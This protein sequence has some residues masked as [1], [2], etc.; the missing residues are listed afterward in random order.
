MRKK[1]TQLIVLD[2]NIVLRSETERA[3]RTAL[4]A[5]LGLS[6]KV[7]QVLAKGMI[8]GDSKITIAITVEP[9]ESAD[10]DDSGVEIL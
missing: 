8:Y 4:D 7:Q 9:V 3:V 10:N 5:I 6:P 1:S 2:R